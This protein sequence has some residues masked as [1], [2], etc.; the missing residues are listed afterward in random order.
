MK[1]FEDL[2]FAKI[3]T[4][5]LYRKGCSEAVY[6]EC[7]TDKQLIKI[8]KT[9]MDKGQNIIGTRASLKQAEILKK[10]L[11]KFIMMILQKL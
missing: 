1:N 6:C 10:S 8:F 2:G 3:D 4:Q 9:L 7:K 11:K 5:R